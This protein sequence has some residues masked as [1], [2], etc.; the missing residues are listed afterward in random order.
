MMLSLLLMKNILSMALMVVMGFA[1]T[2]LGALHEQDTVPLSALNLYV[3]CP[4]MVISSFQVELTADRLHRFLF[5]LAAA[6]IIHV[7]YI[8]LSGALQ[9][10]THMKPVY[11][12]S[13]EF[14]N[15][16]NLILP[17]VSAVLGEE[18]VFYACAYVMVTTIAFWTHGVLVLGG[19]DKVSARKILTNPNMIAVFAG[20]LLFAL[21]VKLPEVLLHA[22]DSVGA[23]VG[24]ISMFIVGILMG[25][26]N[27]KEV[28]SEKRTWIV[29]FGR[30]IVYPLLIILLFELTA[31]PVWLPFS[32]ELFVISLLAAAGP[33]AS[34]VVSAARL[35]ERDAV[36]AGAVNVMSMIFCIATMPAMVFVYEKI[37][38]LVFGA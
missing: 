15:A 27:L 31:A 10:L 6:V 20:L 30:L 34:N 28:F 2:R 17:L 7:V 1:A 22:V 37:T 35:Y 21:R 33:S 16:G 13:L 12:A 29:C 26:A 18:M 36:A 32:R 38:T 14:P 25:A 3:I 5:V 11:R 8:A 4:C 23:A 9:R 19:K 24:P